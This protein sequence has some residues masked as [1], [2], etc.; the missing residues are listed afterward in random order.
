MEIDAEN[1][2]G[3]GDCSHCCGEAVAMKPSATVS[4][5]LP[6]LLGPLVL[7]VILLRLDVTEIAAVLERVSVLPV[8]GACLAVLPTLPLRSWRW[9]L[10]LE[11]AGTRLAPLEALN[12][13]A[14]SIV[15]GSA[16][17][18]RLG[19]LIK[20]GYLR[21]KGV[22]TSVAV[23]SVA[24][25]RLFDLA[26]LIVVGAGALA[27]FFGG[28]SATVLL[29][30]LLA[31]AVFCAAVWRYAVSSHGRR[32]AQGLF[33]RLLPAAWSQRFP[34][35]IASVVGQA[36]ALPRSTLLAVGLLTALTWIATYL[37]VYLCAVGL[38]LDVP[39][40]DICGVT[41]ISSLVTFLPI[42]ILGLGT[43]DASLIALLAPYGVP[44]TGAVALSALYLGITLWV[45]LVCSYSLATP[46][47][48]AW[49]RSS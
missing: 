19:E 6:R 14:F 9:R 43:R 15:V 36:K 48:G 23:L 22:A 45:V 7:A 30:I 20:I 38:G 49:R 17:P 5:W 40:F 47:A 8:A 24:L 39:F 46:A 26:F 25:D 41:A 16:T 3:R 29:P 21:N 31:M 28:R 11:G 35:A 42:S 12:A 37:A 13:Y 27:A 1:G 34:R 4:R 33:S 2:D 44:A 18:G 10:L 32:V